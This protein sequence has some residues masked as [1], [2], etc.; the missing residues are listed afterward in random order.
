MRWH[1]LESYTSGLRL[2]LRAVWPA[3]LCRRLARA[4]THAH[5]P[6]SAAFLPSWRLKGVDSDDEFTKQLGLPL[7]MSQ[8]DLGKV[9]MSD[10][11][12]KERGHI[13]KKLDCERGCTVWPNVYAHLIMPSVCKS[14][15]TFLTNIRA[16]YEK[17]MMN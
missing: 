15:H 4:I 2:C 16:C 9:G 5:T 10:M 13:S 12:L 1:R 14:S 11:D 6:S 8:V 7:L 17:T 3:M